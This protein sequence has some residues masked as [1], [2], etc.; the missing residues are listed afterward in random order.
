MGKPVEELTLDEL[1]REEMRCRNLLRCFAKAKASKGI[2]KRLR[3]IENRI[4]A[5]NKD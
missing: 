4:R 2:E 5:E 3:E 1:R